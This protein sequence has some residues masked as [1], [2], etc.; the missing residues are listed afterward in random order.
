MWP[1]T[2]DVS[3]KVHDRRS[4]YALAPTLH[5]TRLSIAYRRNTCKAEFGKSPG[6]HMVS[7]RACTVCHVER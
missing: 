1:V 5:A 7:I 4:P 6:R 2:M 3:A